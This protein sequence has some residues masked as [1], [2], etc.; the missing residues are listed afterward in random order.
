MRPF[1]VLAVVLVACKGGAK[2]TDER[3][4]PI[5]PEDDSCD[6]TTPKVCRGGDVIECTVD[7]HLGRRLRAC[8]DGCKMGQCEMS[9]SDDGAKLIYLVDSENDFLSFD[10][11]KLPDDPFHLVGK[12]RCPDAGSPFSMSVDRHG[13]AWVVY[14]DGRLFNVSIE[15]AHCTP[16]TLAPGAAGAHTFGMGFSTDAPGAK[17]EKLYLAANDPTRMLS[18]L[19]P[20]TLGIAQRGTLTATTEGNPE[21]TGTS[22][23]RLY[24]FYPTEIDAPFVQEIDPH[25]GAPLGSRWPIAAG[26]IGRI[27]AYAFAQW[28]GTFY[29]FATVR[30]GDFS[31]NSTIRTVDHDG[32]WKLILQNLP[33]RV[34]GAGVSTCAP[35][36]DQ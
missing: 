14:D 1:V 6:P 8:H 24:G 36:R 30:D 11:R 4:E 12:L 34:T 31:E 29:V 5:A 25:S 33:Y 10:P 17:T 35:E 20:D 27:A 21:L 9:C 26:S 2:G 32:H 18:A 3:V 16:T 15:D 13:I 23:A 19:D 22:D 28:G 7:G